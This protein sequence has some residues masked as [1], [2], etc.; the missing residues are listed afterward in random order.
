MTFTLLTMFLLLLQTTNLLFNGWRYTQKFYRLHR[1]I[2]DFYFEYPSWNLRSNTRQRVTLLLFTC[3]NFC[4]SGGTVNFLLPFMTNVT[5][6]IP[7]CPFLSSDIPSPRAYDV[8][9]S[10]LI[11]YSRL[12]PRIYVLF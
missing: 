9:I 3:I 12:A 11:R 6:S 4:R 10:Q 1:R 7:I 2:N 5:I 8:F